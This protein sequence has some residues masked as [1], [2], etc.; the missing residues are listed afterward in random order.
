MDKRDTAAVDAPRT[1]RWKTVTVSAVSGAAVFALGYACTGASAPSAGSAGPPV[2]I[3]TQTP[4][5]SDAFGNLPADRTKPSSAPCATVRRPA[6]WSKIENAK[7]GDSSWRSSFDA[8]TSVVAGYLNQVSAACGDTLELHLSGYVSSASVTA[9]R[10]GWYGGTGGRVVWS[11][12]HVPVIASPVKNSGAP[13]Y[14]VEASWPVAERIPV[15]A[16]WTPGYYLIVIR[17][18]PHDDGDAIP[19]IIRDDSDGN[20]PPGSGSSPLL[21][22]A[23]V[24]TYQA[25]NN[26]GRY[27]LYYGPKDL[28]SKRTDRSR[29]ASFDRPYNGDGYRAPFLYDIPL[30][31]E[32]EKLGLDVDYTTDIDVDERPS[33]V[34]AHKALLIGGHSEYWTRRMYDAA[35][36]ARHKGTNIGFFG[37]NEIYWHARLEPSPSG[38]DRRMVV[39]RYANEDPLAKSDPSQAT[40]LWNSPQLQRPENSI[41]GPAY[42][43]LG[44]DGGAFRILQPDSWIFAGTGVTKDQYLKNSLAGEYDTVKSIGGTPPDIDVIAAAPIV[45][46]GQSTMATMSYYTDPSGAGVFAGGMTY[47]DCQMAQMC[48]DRPVDPGT[49]HVL[50]AVTDNVLR[51]YAQGP[52]GKRYPSMYRPAPSAQALIS[53]AP[54]LSD[55]GVGPPKTSTSE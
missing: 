45:F 31:E 10:M 54:S 43:E 46:S 22:Q 25:Y 38:P 41:V 4:E 34:A 29:V 9:Y 52:A 1:A 8:D 51:T 2:K 50:A 21:L 19:L 42:G 32:A 14:T 15:T 26:Y 36:Y 18:K 12:S 53:T 30:A 7:P 47:W 39:Y 44:A 23:S 5:A 24:L 13:T 40:V 35:V 16:A 55:V 28:S 6:G 49:A 3:A 48:G 20:G 33:Q 17:A 11:T 27:S 37:A